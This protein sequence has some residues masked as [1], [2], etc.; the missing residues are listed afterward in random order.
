MESDMAVF[1]LRRM[2][3]GDLDWVFTLEV[4]ARTV[5]MYL[6]TVGLVRVL[7]KRGMRQLA[8]FELVIIIALGSS[9]GDP[10]LYPDVPLLHGMA[11][12]TTVVL[13]QQ[14]VAF[15]TERSPRVEHA[16]ESEP[17]LVVLGG[18]LMPETMHRERIARDELFSDLREREVEN[19]GE[20]REAYLEPSG[21]LSVFRFGDGEGPE[22]G[23]SLIPPPNGEPHRPPILGMPRVCMDCGTPAGDG[24][25]PCGTCESEDNWTSAAPVRRQSQV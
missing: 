17:A 21:A 19:L 11:V 2:F 14:A 24:T 15:G 5:I 9:V 7:G 1:E 23:L 13:L 3:L 16:L 12:I 8:P 6:Y 22:Y 4:V 10:M 25:D 18:R 20:V